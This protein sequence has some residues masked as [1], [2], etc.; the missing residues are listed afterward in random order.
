[1]IIIMIMPFYWLSSLNYIYSHEKVIEKKKYYLLNLVFSPFFKNVGIQ[2]KK[3]DSK[4][5]SKI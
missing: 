1:M 2:L 4:K 3:L 5:K